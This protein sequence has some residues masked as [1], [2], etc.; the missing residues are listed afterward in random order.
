MFEGEVADLVDHEKRHVHVLAPSQTLGADLGIAF[1]SEQEL[2]AAFARFK[3]LADKKH[4]IFDD[5]LQALVTDV[6]MATENERIKLIS[7][8]VCSETG[9]TPKADLVL[10]VDGDLMGS[11]AAFSDRVKSSEGRT[12]DLLISREDQPIKVV[13]DIAPT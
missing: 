12:L 1:D 7:L 3:D 6:N 5:D 10:A 2:N 11:F 13:I 9:E 4:E 8:K